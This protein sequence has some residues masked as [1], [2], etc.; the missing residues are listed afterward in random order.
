MSALL[1]QLVDISLIYFV[2]D[3]KT[4]SEQDYEALRLVERSETVVQSPSWEANSSLATQE[5][6][7]ILWIP[8]VHYRIHKSPP[9]IPI[10]SQIDAVHLPHT[11]SL[12]SILNIR[13]CLLSGLPPSG[14]PTKTLYAP[15]L[16][17]YVLHAL[18]IP[19]FLTWSPE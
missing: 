8:K 18:P 7:R 10:L 11:T 6:P 5:I 15:L 3:L 1:S 16:S 13:L 4:E 2:F 17:P 14:F 9:T 19:V 12:T